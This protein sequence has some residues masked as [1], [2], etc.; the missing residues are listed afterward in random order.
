[1]KF[2]LSGGRADP[3][4]RFAPKPSGF[5]ANI[6]SSLFGQAF[7]LLTQLAVL[8]SMSHMRGLEAVGQFGLAMA[9][10]NPPFILFGYGLR[11]TQAVDAG[12]RYRFSEYLGARLTGALLASMVALAIGVTFAQ[13]V[14]GGILLSVTLMKWADAVCETC[15]G[16]YQRHERLGL[17]ARSLMLRGVAGLVL[18]HLLLM[19]GVSIAGSLFAQVIV[20]WLVAVLIDFPAASALGGRR[21][22]WPRL[23]I[24]PNLR[25]LLSSLPPSLES[26]IYNLQ[27]SGQRGIVSNV[28]SPA[29]LGVFT[30]IEYVHQAGAMLANAMSQALL[31]RLS[32]LRAERD[33][34]AAQR[35]VLVHAAVMLATGIAGVVVA[36]L[37]GKTLLRFFFHIE[38]A[39]AEDLL[40]LIA[41]AIAIRNLATGVSASLS[42]SDRFRSTLL[43]QGLASTVAVAAALQLVPKFGLVGAGLA[44][45]AGA[46]VHTGV[47]FALYVR[48][49]RHGSRAK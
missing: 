20:W 18:F 29:L 44:I 49:E 10:A 42:A 33:H 17:Q 27:K 38:S 46:V 39:V 37:L 21:L 48:G 22:S 12:N 32:Q 34:R 25:L 2:E 47:T 28:L 5:G 40:T 43:V 8:S 16:A 1:M 15:Y 45:V 13:G 35:I 19:A 23:A 6:G 3:Q 9:I 7:F 30:A 36:A 14:P 31:G 41:I 11:V 26:L 24:L 4:G